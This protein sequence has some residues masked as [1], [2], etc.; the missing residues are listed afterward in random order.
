M[1]ALLQR[2]S[3]ASVA[4]AENTIGQ[5][6]TGLLVL[7]G[8]HKRD[9]DEDLEYIARKILGLRIFPDDQGRMNR[10][11]I[12]ANGSILLVSQFTLYA[13]TGKGRRPGFEFAA[14][15]ETAIPL[16]EEMA[17]RLRQDV[18]VSTGEFGAKMVVSL[19]NDGPVTIMLDSHNR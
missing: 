14:P 12:D 3:S 11:L 18:S 6:G 4:V 7:L 17:R 16:Y 10:S 2:V 15:P 9:V 19:V 13:D 5:I 1:R 8:V